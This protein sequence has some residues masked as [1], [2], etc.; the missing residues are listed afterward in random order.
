MGRVAALV[1]YKI[2]FFLGPAFR[3][4]LGPLV[5]LGLLVLFLPQGFFLGLGLGMAIREADL[6]RAGVLLAAPLAGLLSFGFLW[7]LGTGVTAHASE[8]D[9]FL[10]ADVRPREYLVADLLFQVTSVL[11]TG[12]LA[13]SLAAVGIAVGAGRPIVAAAPLLAIL[14]AYLVLVFLLVQV[15][16][17]LRVQHPK[18]P[19]RALL[20]ALLVLS[21]LP[22]L[23]LFRPDLGLGLAAAPLPSNAFA[24]LGAAVLRG[25][26]IILQDILV[27]GLYAGLVAAAW[28]V[29]S[30]TYIFHGIRPALSAG[31]GQVSLSAKMDQQRRIIGGLGPLTTLV[32]LRTE[33]G[34]ETSLMARL[35]LVRILRDGSV[36]FIVLLA[37]VWTFP[38]AF[39]DEGLGQAGWGLVLTQMVAF[40][41]AILAMNW[42][43]YERENLWI[44]QAAAGSAASYFR[45]LLLGLAGIGLAMTAAGYAILTLASGVPPPLEDVALPVAASFAAALGATAFLTRVRIA[46]SAFSPALLAI[47]LVVIIAGFMAGLAAQGLVVLVDRAIGVSTVVR[48]FVVTA[49]SLGLLAFGLYSVTRLGAAFRL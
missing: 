17:V 19:I 18:K 29:V 4:R 22:S 41:I 14:V 36:L 27:A 12:G 31:L 24:A 7:A 40:T 11:L 10:T 6:A 33:R 30:D 9:F 49:F 34:G 28:L 32:R 45:G 46:P 13:A 8:F 15:F 5:F 25:T 37:V 42:S 48:A 47:L 35:H 26:P 2:Q 16:I 21:L 1:R 44:V 39:R 38:A 3:G 20:V 43:Y 23:E